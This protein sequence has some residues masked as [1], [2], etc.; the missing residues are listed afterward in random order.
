MHNP[1]AATFLRT[2]LSKYRTLFRFFAKKTEPKN[3]PGLSRR[4]RRCPASAVQF[5]ARQSA[6]FCRFV[7]V[8]KCGW[9]MVI[10]IPPAPTQSDI[11]DVIPRLFCSRFVWSIFQRCRGRIQH[12]AKRNATSRK[13]TVSYRPHGCHRCDINRCRA[14]ACSCH[15]QTHRTVSTVTAKRSIYPSLS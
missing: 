7:T 14:G 11:G 3:R 12:F 10:R 4:P 2:Y 15:L 5:L 1:H 13:T 9:T 6:T 8:T